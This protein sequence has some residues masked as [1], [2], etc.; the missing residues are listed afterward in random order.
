MS[1]SLVTTK[2][3]TNRKDVSRAKTGF[4]GILV[5]VLLLYIISRNLIVTTTA[6]AFFFPVTGTVQFRCA[7]LLL[8]LCVVFGSGKTKSWKSLSPWGGAIVGSYLF[9]LLI[10]AILVIC[11]YENPKQMFVMFIDTG[12]V[13][14]ALVMAYVYASNRLQPRDALR[15]MLQPY[16][17]LSIYIAA[18]GLAAWSLVFFNIVEPSDWYLPAGMLKKDPFSNIGHAYTMPYYLG[19]VLHGL[20]GGVFLGLNF[21][22]ACGLFYE[23]HIAAFFVTPTLFLLPFVFKERASKWKVRLT[24]VL[25]CAFLFVTHSVSSMAV[26]A[27][28]GVMF[29]GKTL[30]FDRSINRKIFVLFLFSLLIIFSW[31]A[32]NSPG[33]INSKLIP[34]MKWCCTNYLGVDFAD[35][36]FGHE[37][38]TGREGEFGEPMPISLFLVLLLHRAIIIVLG[39]KVFFSGRQWWYAGG[40]ALYLVGHSIKGYMAF[41]SGVYLY[42]IFIFAIILACC[43]NTDRWKRVNFC[44][45]DQ[46]TSET[47]EAG[48]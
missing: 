8:L 23:P 36:L 28:I 13:M 30:M 22:R 7:I 1:N 32:V 17:Y 19:I 18:A 9:V 21:K 3:L 16:C 41:L 11:G 20:G 42:V 2:V 6:S 43:W 40:A 12:I 46:I 10:E 37:I 39:I 25:L 4:A 5:Q 45:N 33:T 35:A 47:D 26:L 31:Q 34:G 38:L 14:V 44:N 27:C 15:F 48:T 29:I 24:Y